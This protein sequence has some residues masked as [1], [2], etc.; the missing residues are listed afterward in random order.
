MSPLLGSTIRKRRLP[1]KLVDLLIAVYP[2]PMNSKIKFLILALCLVALGYCFFF[3]GFF[4]TF[5]NFIKVENLKSFIDQFGVLAPLVF[6]ALY[7]GLVLAF[8]SAAAFSVLAGLLFGKI[9][10]TVYVIIAATLAAQ[11]AFFI[12]RQ[13]SP[14]KLNTLKQKKGIG[15]LIKKIETQ[16]ENHGFKSIF[17]LRCLFAP[18]IPLSYA[19]GMIKTLKAKDFFF[20]TLGTNLIFTPAFVFLGD[21]LLE[22]PKALLLPIIMVTLVLLVPKIIK[23]FKPDTSL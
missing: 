1:P 3:T 7:Y 9:W 16:T 12:T 10:G 2:K 22:G 5:K 8:I 19:A 17:L 11:T 14:E 20:A 13:V 4:E 23:Y 18:Y 6:V 21:S 15:A